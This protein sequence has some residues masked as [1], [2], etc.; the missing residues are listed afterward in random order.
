MPYPTFESDIKEGEDPSTINS[1]VTNFWIKEM[2]E[3]QGNDISCSV[4]SDLLKRI[5]NSPLINFQPCFDYLFSNISK[6]VEWNDAFCGMS[7]RAKLFDSRLNVK[8]LTNTFE[9]SIRDIM[10]KDPRF[11]SFLPERFLGE[12]SFIRFMIF[13]LKINYNEV[14]HRFIAIMAENSMNIN[15]S[16]KQTFPNSGTMARGRR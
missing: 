5:G 9:T 6:N 12:Q 16:M 7:I 4:M 8:N 1:L 11:E 10:G 15:A 14:I 3:I 13:G 2:V